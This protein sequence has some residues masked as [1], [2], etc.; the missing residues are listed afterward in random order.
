MN[1]S[2]RRAELLGALDCGAHALFDG[3]IACPKLEE[4]GLEHPVSHVVG[5]DPDAD[6]RRGGT[7]VDDAAR[8][9][10]RGETRDSLH[11]P[12]LHL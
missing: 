5:H 10:R 9:E 11:E 4:H 1:A 8:I 12:A 6:T 2:V 3:P 7:Y